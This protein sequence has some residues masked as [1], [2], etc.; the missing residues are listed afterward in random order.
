MGT[1]SSP[2][3]HTVHALRIKGSATVPNLSDMTRATPSVVQQHLD[4]LAAAGLAEVRSAPA[5][6]RLTPAGEALHAD[7]LRAEVDGVLPDAGFDDAVRR[8]VALDGQFRRLFGAWQLFNGQPNDHSSA[9]YDAAV[10][11]NL[12]HLHTAAEPTVNAFGAVFERMG[13]YGPRLES[14]LVRILDGE[15]NMFTGVM[16]GSYHDVWME[17]HEDLLLTQGLERSTGGGR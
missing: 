4:V 8:F 11:E 9:E 16:C 5:Q 15:S 2:S 7:A 10:I 14:V 17:L 12:S 6:W 1:P 13:N 3:F